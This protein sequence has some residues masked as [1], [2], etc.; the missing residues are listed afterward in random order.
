[1][2]NQ[3]R[4]LLYRVSEGAV[5]CTADVLFKISVTVLYSGSREY[6]DPFTCTFLL[7]IQIVIIGY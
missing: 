7:K 5:Y 6:S 1:M 3:A 2:S 4:M